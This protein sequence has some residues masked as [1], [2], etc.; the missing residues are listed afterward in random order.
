MSDSFVIPTRKEIPSDAGALADAT[1]V[2]A[3]TFIVFAVVII[4][5]TVVTN[6]FPLDAIAFDNSVIFYAFAAYHASGGIHTDVFIIPVLTSLVIFT[7]DF[8]L[9]LCC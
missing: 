1:I 4:V 9:R 8:Y 3:L 7:G 5:F 6:M 2:S